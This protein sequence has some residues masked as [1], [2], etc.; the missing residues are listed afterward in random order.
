MEIYYLLNDFLKYNYLEN[1]KSQYILNNEIII[2][3]KLY[4]ELIL[5]VLVENESILIKYLDKLNEYINWLGKRCKKYI[6]NCYDN[7]IE[8][9]NG[10]GGL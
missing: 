5:S 1:V 9:T 6:I 8:N 4:E 10:Y 2:F 3:H 7:I